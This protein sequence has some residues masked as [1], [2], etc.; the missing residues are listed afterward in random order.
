VALSHYAFRALPLEQQLPLVWMEGTFLARRWEEEDHVGLYH[1]DGSFFCEVY[2]DPETNAIL[3]T[4]TFTSAQCLEDYAC[5][6]SLRDLT[7]TD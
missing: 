3:R 1:M 4:R 5:Y 6:V 7:N 2:Y